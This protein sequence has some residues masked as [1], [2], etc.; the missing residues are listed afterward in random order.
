MLETKNNEVSEL[1]Q[2]LLEDPNVEVSVRKGDIYALLVETFTSL[3]EYQK[4]VDVIEE[5]KSV[6]T[7]NP[8]KYFKGDTLQVQIS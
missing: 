3:G 6:L 1:I 8:V 7:H 5:M 2:Q 4:A